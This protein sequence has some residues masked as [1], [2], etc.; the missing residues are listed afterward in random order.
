[1]GIPFWLRESWANISIG[2]LWY[3][4]RRRWSN[5]KGC[6]GFDGNWSCSYSNAATIVARVL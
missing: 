2:Q 3:S 1:M 5:R 6:Y 4:Q